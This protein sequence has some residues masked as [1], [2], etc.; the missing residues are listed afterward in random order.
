MDNLPL[1]PIAG[2][3]SL[4]IGSFVNPIGYEETVTSLV[5]IAERTFMLNL[6]REVESNKNKFDI[7]IAPQ[8]LKRYKILDPEKAVEVFEIGYRATKE[9]LDD[10]SVKKILS[11]KI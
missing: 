6:A 11:D 4:K 9:Q 8:E 5:Q 3:C 10:P 7:F 2:L 1:K